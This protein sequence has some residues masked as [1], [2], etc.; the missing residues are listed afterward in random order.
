[1]AQLLTTFH[2]KYVP[3]TEVNNTKEVLHKIPLGGD[4]LTEEC[5]RK[6]QKTYRLG[7]T[8]FDHLDGLETNHADWHWKVKLFEVEVFLYQ[9]K[10][11]TLY[12]PIFCLLL[13]VP[14]TG[15]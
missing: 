3:A 9:L 13:T 4:Q 2:D 1:M 5:A 11:F 14:C 15:Y 7:A 6:L 12:L 10:P 8:S